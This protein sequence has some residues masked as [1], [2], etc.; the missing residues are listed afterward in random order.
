MHEIAFVLAMLA[1]VAALVLLANRLDLPY[2]I[3]LVLGGLTLGFMPGVPEIE[4][5]PEIVFLVFLPP[6]LYWD[7]VTTSWRDFRT[8]L[9]PIAS[10]AIGL[11]VATT[12]GVAVVAHYLLDLSWGVGF[13]LGSIV[14]ATDA[15]ATGSIARR[16]GVP[17]RIVAI[18][19]GESLVNDA[20]AL[21]VYGTAVGAVVSGSFS[22]THAT[23]EFVLVC[24]G[25]VAIGLV[26]GWLI[27]W[28][29]R[30]IDDNRVEGLMS[31]LTPFAAFL[32]AHELGVSGVLAAVAA[33]LYLGRHAPSAVSP[34]VRLRATVVWE[35]G[36]FVVNGLVFILIGLSFPHILD[37][38]ESHSVASLL[39]DSLVIGTSVIA[40]RLAWVFL[41]GFLAHLSLPERGVIGWAG[42][43]GVIALATALALPTRTER[44]PFPDRDLVLFLTFAV[45]LI[46]LVGQGL[47][48][49]WLI[50][51]L[52]LVGQDPTEREEARAR[53]VG[54][55][56]ALRYLDDLADRGEVTSELLDELRGRYERRASRVPGAVGPDVEE[57]ARTARAVRRDL[58]ATEHRAL[59]KLRD[60][61][62]I[63]D[64]T[65][66]RIQQELDLEQVRL[67]PDLHG[68]S[69]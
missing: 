20:T 17:P 46:T 1:V 26:V 61:G 6:L 11:V 51:R 29:R 21:V 14:A 25:G 48:L 53:L 23:V 45:I 68:R 8:N 57:Y 38:I 2:P 24:A 35:L 67:D 32:P 12:C 30:R 9:Q 18:L 50:R 27:L 15:V 39:W 42:L 3:L 64:E 62:A 13:V 37:G 31:L 36:T 10:L 63:G 58:L 5:D 7:A 54:T 65:L 66:R 56:A 34:T 16:L 19:H 59:V 43:R 60:R 55:R 40:L 22:L 69:S 41:G 47:S 4:L 49:P 33:G 52:G 44:G 28:L